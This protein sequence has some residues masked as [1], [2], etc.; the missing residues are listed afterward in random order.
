MWSRFLS[1]VVAILFFVGGLLAAEAMVVKYDPD[2]KQVVLKV[3]D[4]EHTV[5]LEEVKVIGPNGKEVKDL[6]KVKFRKEAKVE[7]T[8]EGDKITEIKIIRA[9]KN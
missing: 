5:K 7:V 6:T 3:G 9:K 4:K 1:A 2:T 8:Q